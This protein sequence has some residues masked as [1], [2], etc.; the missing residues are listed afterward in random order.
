MGGEVRSTNALLISSVSE[1][2]LQGFI[3]AGLIS[4]DRRLSPFADAAT[5]VSWQT[6]ED[7]LMDK[8]VL[9]DDL[10]WSDGKPVTAHDIAFSFQVI[11]D[12]RVP[13]PAVR[14]GTDELRWVHAYDDRTIVYFHKESK[15]TNV[16]N[17][18]FPFLPKHL[19]ES[20]YVDDPTLAKSDRHVELE[21][22]PVCCGAYTIARRQRGGEIVLKR[23]EGFYLHQ[24]KEVREK[25]YF[26]T[27]RFRIIEDSNTALLAIK[28]GNIDETNLIP[29]QW[30]KQTQD[31]EFTRRN[32]KVKE[33]EWTSWH[34]CWNLKS[35][36]FSDLRVR[37][38]M[39]YAFDYEE[40]LGRLAYGLYEPSSGSFHRGSW[41]APKEYPS[42][43]KQDLDKAE[44][45][46]EEAGWTDSDG[47]GIRDKDGR[48]FQF[49]LSYRSDPVLERYCNVM[50]ESLDKIGI[51]CR[52]GPIEFTV[53]QQRMLDHNFDAS[54]GGWG[55]GADPDT[56]RN[57]MGSGE[58]RNFGS[59]SNP[60]VD[61]LFKQ[62]AREF[63]RS[64]RGELYGK[65]HSI[66]FEEQPYLYLYW[67]ASF[68]AFN[69]ELRGYVMSP[70][71][72][73]NYSPGASAIWR[74][75]AP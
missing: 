12:E 38:A 19:Y 28:S 11:M 74:V 53:L 23:R 31:D 37:R 20:S 34:V 2:D 54:F 40:L 5:C 67:R 55:T 73:F 46:L 66:L 16:W 7:R 61:E 24:G 35:P 59:Y 6:S 32:T 49:T 69:K 3:N 17:I 51:E 9:R 21:N 57:I 71:G 72:P 26:D 65:I 22:N 1:F 70:R 39:A 41:M 8:I 68:Y 29:E 52:L 50:R 48:P 27:I 64:K 13:V 47:D 43:Y 15:A 4:F 10:T 60:Q 44:A 36:F 63:D 42:P 58:E 30:V 56:F 18:A 33:T 14:S 62:A 25:P 75:A 45:L